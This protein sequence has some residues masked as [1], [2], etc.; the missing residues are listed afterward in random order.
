MKPVMRSD[1]KDLVVS[2]VLL[3]VNYAFTFMILE[4]KPQG[5]GGGR[6]RRGLDQ[7]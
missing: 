7:Y 1:S 6:G 3:D 5:G 2:I 4:T